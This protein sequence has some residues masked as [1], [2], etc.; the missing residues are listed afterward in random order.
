MQVAHETTV[1]VAPR[2]GEQKK[3]LQCTVFLHCDGFTAA[4]SL[5]FKPVIRIA[6]VRT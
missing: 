2:G 1:L 5:I 4:L 3:T 6:Y